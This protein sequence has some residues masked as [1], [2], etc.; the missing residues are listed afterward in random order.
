MISINIL[1][2]FTLFVIKH[3]IADFLWQSETMV[4]E[5][6]T[7]GA[8]GGIRHSLIHA[9]FTFA[10]VAY[11]VNLPMALLASVIDFVVHYHVDWAKMNISKNLTPAH[12]E[13]WIWLGAD[14]LLHY[15]T[16]IGIIYVIVC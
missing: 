11:V 8:L 5:K 4:K 10:I 6:G 16:Y 3:F 7:Y 14:Q 2:L 15:L 13:F 9:I 12:K 1:L